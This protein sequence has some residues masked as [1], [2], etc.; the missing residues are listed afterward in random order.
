MDPNNPRILY[1]STWEMKRN[2]YRMDSGGPDSRMFKSTDGGDNWTDISEASGLPGFPWG[3]VGIAV[4]PLDS[5]RVW[6]IIE[7]SE[8]KNLETHQPEPRPEAT[9]LVLQSDLRRPSECG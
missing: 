4:S 5:N 3:I 9:G 8:G 6:A 7:A 2:G 1:A